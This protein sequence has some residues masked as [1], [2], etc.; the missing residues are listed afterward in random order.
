[1]HGQPKV[2]CQGMADSCHAAQAARWRKQQRKRIAPLLGAAM[3]RQAA[4]AAGS[5]DAEDGAA[6]QPK[7]LFRSLFA[8][9]EPPSIQ[10]RTAGVLDADRSETSLDE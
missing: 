2:F 6:G 10:S 8:Q 4:A 3:A 7:G 1:M 9:Q 5:E